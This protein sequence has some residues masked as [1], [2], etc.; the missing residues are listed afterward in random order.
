MVCVVC[1][2]IVRQQF[3]SMTKYPDPAWIW[4]IWIQCTPSCNY[5]LPRLH[6]TEGSVL[7]HAWVTV[8]KSSPRCTESIAVA[9]SKFAFNQW[10]TNNVLPPEPDSVFE[11]LMN[12]W[13]W[14]HQHILQNSECVS[15][16][17]FLSQRKSWTITTPITNNEWQQILVPLAYRKPIQSSIYEAFLANV[18]YLP[19]E[20]SQESYAFT[21]YAFAYWAH[22]QIQQRAA[23]VN[24][25]TSQ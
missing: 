16:F 4:K 23:A 10:V 8:M 15:P 13:V 20:A 9:I 2:E 5:G 25:I 19:S 22:I 1:N 6:Y 7:N 18:G 11:H 17:L 12:F 24:I 21:I 3:K 14:I